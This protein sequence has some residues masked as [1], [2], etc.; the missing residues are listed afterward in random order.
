VTILEENFALCDP[1]SEQ[2]KDVTAILVEPTN[3]GTT[4]V[5]KL[6]YML[7]E[8]EYQVD[9][10]SL[11]D[12]YS[13][14]RQQTALLKH[15]FKFEKV[16][17]I[18]YTTRSLHSEENEQVVED[19]LDRHG[20]EWKLTCV[21]P[22]IP[23]E[24]ISDYEY[25]EC[26]TIHPEE[27]NGNGIFIAHFTLKPPE[28]IKTKEI[29]RTVASVAGMSLG[30]IEAEEPRKST[31]KRETG[32]KKGEHLRIKLP[33]KLRESVK[34]LSAPRFYYDQTRP[35]VNVITSKIPELQAPRGAPISTEEDHKNSFDIEAFGKSLK[36]FFVPKQQAMLSID[37]KKLGGFKKG[38]SRYL[39]PVLML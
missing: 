37:Q 23:S 12:L 22:E 17:D 30:D 4:I 6:S 27:V 2:F 36:E 18:L 31:K 39:Y 9:S 5:D 33:K 34:R 1:R 28:I 26:L 25:D 38:S 7:Q 11:K 14:K 24:K 3:S 10:F 16:H 21:L 29:H 15:A 13:L 35:S 32:R 8:E 19:T 20:V